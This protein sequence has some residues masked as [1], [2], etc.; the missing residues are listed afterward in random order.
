MGLLLT[1]E[2]EPGRLGIF[3]DYRSAKGVNRSQSRIEAMSGLV[4]QVGDFEIAGTIPVEGID[5]ALRL[6]R[7]SRLRPGNPEF[8]QSTPVQEPHSA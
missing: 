3:L 2:G 6:I 8:G 4:N 1:D 7:A 5:E